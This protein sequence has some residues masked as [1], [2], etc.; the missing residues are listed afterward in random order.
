MSFEPSDWASVTAVS[1]PWLGLFGGEAGRDL[2]AFGDRLRSG[3]C[4][5]TEVVGYGVALTAPSAAF[6][7]SQRCV[8]WFE[9]RLAPHPSRLAA[10]WLA[11][12]GCQDAV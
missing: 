3:S 6:D 9:R 11:H 10:A 5:Y 1:T 4:A 2:H 8:E 7:A 12:E